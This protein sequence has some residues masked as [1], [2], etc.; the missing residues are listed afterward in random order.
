M[1]TPSIWNWTRPTGISTPVSTGLTVA[2]KET[3]W[4]YTAVAVEAVTMVRVVA[5]AI[6][7]ISAGSL[8]FFTKF[9]PSPR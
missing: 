4:P 3:V 6:P 7:W 9:W 2:V 1:F 8:V 5:A